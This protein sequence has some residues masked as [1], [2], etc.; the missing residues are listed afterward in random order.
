MAAAVGGVEQSECESVQ[1]RQRGCIAKMGRFVGV[2]DA[3][4]D[5]AHE[6]AVECDE[7]LVCDNWMYA[8][9]RGA[10]CCERRRKS[11]LQVN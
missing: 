10:C 1:T 4:E 11:R 6:A 3:A 2:D 7:E 5:V 9:Y 8:E